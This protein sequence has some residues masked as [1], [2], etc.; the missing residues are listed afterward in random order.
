MA[1]LLLVAGIAGAGGYAIADD[2]S[3]VSELH[4]QVADLTASRAGETKR[5]SQLADQLDESD[6][7]ISTL[8][9]KLDS[10]AAEVDARPE[11]KSKT[12]TTSADDPGLATKLT[13]GDSAVAGRLTITPTSLVRISS[14]GDRA[15]HEATVTVRNNTDD[16]ISPFCGDSGAELIDTAGRTFDPEGVI[17]ESSNVCE[18]IQPGLSAT[19]LKFTFQT[20]SAAKPRVLR[21]WGEIDNDVNAQLWKVGP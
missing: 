18:D 11:T 6:A 12:K 15:T 3:K 14:N 5:A 13:L 8:E 9:D 4:H 17:S 19:N 7:T 10:A 2:S 20:P 1:P 21:L 16:D